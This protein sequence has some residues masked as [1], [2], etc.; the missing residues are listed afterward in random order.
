V[1]YRAR[2]GGADHARFAAAFFA[3]DHAGA[4]AVGATVFGIQRDTHLGAAHRVAQRNLD[5]GLDVA[6]ARR[7]FGEFVAAKA[8]RS[9]AGAAAGGKS[10]AQATEKILE[11]VA[12]T[13]STTAS[14]AK[15]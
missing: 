5:L 11:E 6:S 8:A 14:I 12:E 15:A 3:R 13:A 7:L 1:T 9:A 2:L 10:A 4:A